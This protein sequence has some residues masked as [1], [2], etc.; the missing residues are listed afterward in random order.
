MVCVTGPTTCGYM[1]LLVQLCLENT[2]KTAN[3]TPNS[4]RVCQHITH[5]FTTFRTMYQH[6]SGVGTHL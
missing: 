2:A 5:A 6:M 3:V 1:T 4:H